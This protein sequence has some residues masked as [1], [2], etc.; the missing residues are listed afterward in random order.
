MEAVHVLEDGF[1]VLGET[2]TL[3]VLNKRGDSCYVRVMVAPGAGSA[4]SLSSRLRIGRYGVDGVDEVDFPLSGSSLPEELATATP[5]VDIEGTMVGHPSSAQKV[6]VT[7]NGKQPLVMRSPAIPGSDFKVST[8]GCAGLTLAPGDSCSIGVRATPTAVGTR[9]SMLQVYYDGGSH[10]TTYFLPISLSTTA[11]ATTFDLSAAPEFGEVP[12]RGSGEVKTLTATNNSGKAISPVSVSLGGGTHFRITATT[13]SGSLAEGASC[14]VSVSFVPKVAG[15]IKDQLV[16]TYGSGSLIAR[17][18]AGTG[19]RAPATS[20]SF[21]GQVLGS[22]PA[23]RQVAITNTL[24]SPATV[25]TPV[26]TGGFNV[27]QSTCGATLA[28]GATCQAWVTNWLTV[29][30]PAAGSLSFNIGED[31]FSLPLA[32]SARTF[33]KAL[34]AASAGSLNFEDRVASAVSPVKVIRITNQTFALRKLL[35]PTASSGFQV[36]SATTTCTTV[37]RL[38]SGAS[39]NVGIRSTSGG[40][41]GVRTGVLTVTTSD[42]SYAL[43][44]PLSAKSH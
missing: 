26:A 34:V 43:P 11:S 23:Y 25:S 1:K 9:T 21:G 40:V 29:L 7:N 36:D 13:C 12:M 42:R 3:R 18:L 44:I 31:S 33:I 35:V 8:N 10:M 30:G 2:C 15:R 22:S 17:P 5:S 4:D 6:N 41:T 28:A 19:T 24:S 27:A 39:C 37:I 20:P 38:S 14:S 16:L 32:T